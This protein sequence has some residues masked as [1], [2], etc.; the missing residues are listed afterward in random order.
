MT[1]WT[2]KNREAWQDCLP[3]NALSGKKCNFCVDWNAVTHFVWDKYVMFVMNI[4]QSL[5]PA[6]WRCSAVSPSAASAAA[7]GS[8]LKSCGHAPSSKSSTR[9]WRKRTMWPQLRRYG[10][11]SRPGP[12]RSVL[13]VD[14][15]HFVYCCCVRIE[16]NSA[17]GSVGVVSG[18]AGGACVAEFIYRALT[19]LIGCFAAW[20][21][22]DDVNMKRK[23]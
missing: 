19:S 13:H 9:R 12:T 20:R 3:Q 14:G 23:K 16:A 4:P 11:V 21:R 2:E 8:F 15:I 22:S 1:D 18:C 17:R 6:S 5:L 7:S 10:W